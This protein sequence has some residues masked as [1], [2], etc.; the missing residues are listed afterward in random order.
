VNEPDGLIKR[1]RY[2][3]IVLK[4]YV[5]SKGS[6]TMTYDL[7][8]FA[9][10]DQIAPANLNTIMAVKTMGLITGTP[11]NKFMPDGYLTRAEAATVTFRLYNSLLE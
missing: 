6:Y 3:D 10:L 4:A 2:A 9:D 1:E 8:A 5:E 7:N 11:D